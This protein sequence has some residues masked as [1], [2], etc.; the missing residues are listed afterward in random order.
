M[1]ISRLIAAAVLAT[2][3]ATQAH[4]D[5]VLRFSS[6]LPTTHALYPAVWQKWQ[7]DVERVTEGRVT[8][9][10]LPKVVG[11]V[12]GQL[13]VVRDGLAD[14]AYIIH[15]YSPGR[16]T[17]TSVAELPFLGNS[18]RANAVGYWRIYHEYLEKFDEHRGVVPLTLWA[19]GPGQ[20][21]WTKG[22]LKDLADLKGEKIRTPGAST[23]PVVEA[24]GATVVQK[25]VT[26]IYELVNAGIVD[27]TLL[28]Q[29]PA[30]AFNLFDGL[31][32]LTLIDGG[33]YTASQAIVINEAKW[34][35]IS[36]ED[37]K[38]IMS[39]SGESM[40]REIARVTDEG[41]AKAREIMREKGYAVE[42]ASPEVMAQLHEALAP[43]E[44]AWAAAAKAKGMENPEKVLSELRAIIAEVDAEAQ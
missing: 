20:L 3:A 43:V 16:F 10:I 42:K 34:N 8:V 4:A 39:V 14:V 35:S 6:F 9:E 29:E 36:E 26:E 5:T 25:P 19:H 33:L 24:M 37:R 27:G 15:G 22:I 12:A 32:N 1:K 44:K 7:S 11:T 30:I 28:S 38:A 2:A 31:R 40:A 13:D 17:M 18:S 41:D 21:W 23:I